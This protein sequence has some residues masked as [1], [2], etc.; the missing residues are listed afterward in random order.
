M[1]DFELLVRLLM[2]CG[3]WVAAV[4]VTT[5]TVNRAYERHQFRKYE[6]RRRRYSEW[7]LRHL[8]EIQ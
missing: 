2:H 5:A 4:V 1:S 6:N 8:D 7:R 3:P